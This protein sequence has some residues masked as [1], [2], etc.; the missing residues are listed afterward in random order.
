MP[1]SFIGKPICFRMR[2]WV[3]FDIHHY[4]AVFCMN[5]SCRKINIFDYD[6]FTIEPCMYCVARNVQSIGEICKIYVKR[7]VSH[8]HSR[9]AQNSININQT[10]ICTCMICICTCMICV[11]TCMLC[12][13]T[14]MICICTCMCWEFVCSMLFDY[15]HII[16]TF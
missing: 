12:I 15:R 7:I 4:T 2:A 16:Y 9:D 10:P 13:C 11:C 8:L 14:C 1:G 5:T 6:I 3:S